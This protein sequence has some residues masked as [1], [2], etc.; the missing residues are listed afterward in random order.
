MAGME[1]S[2]GRRLRAFS[3]LVGLFKARKFTGSLQK[4]EAQ[5]I[6]K[7]V[8]ESI[9]KIQ[10]SELS[11]RMPL[12]VSLASLLEEGAKEFVPDEKASQLVQ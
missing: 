1:G 6:R 2:V 4:A 10:T 5:S 3:E 11:D 12:L 8:S 9:S 7:F